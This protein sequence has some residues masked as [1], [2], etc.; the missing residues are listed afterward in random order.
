MVIAFGSVAHI[1]NALGNIQQGTILYWQDN[2][3]GYFLG[4]FFSNLYD[5]M[6]HN[7]YKNILLG[8]L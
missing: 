1:Y 5:N 8:D 7:R 6:L 2:R 3:L 4:P